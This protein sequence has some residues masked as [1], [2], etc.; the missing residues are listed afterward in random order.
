MFCV[1]GVI[2]IVLLSSVAVR[3]CGLVSCLYVICYFCVDVVC[4]LFWFVRLFVV[5]SLFGCWLIGLLRIL[6]MVV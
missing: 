1:S 3:L 2:L 6:R 4:C 5:F